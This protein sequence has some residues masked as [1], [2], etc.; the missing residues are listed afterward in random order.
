MPSDFIERV[1]RELEGVDSFSVGVSRV[2]DFCESN[3][4]ADEP[5]FSN[6]SCDSCG[7][8]VA[9]DRYPAHGRIASVIC[10]FSIC[11]DC[12]QFHANGDIPEDS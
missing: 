5:Y 4:H 6:C 11:S 10:C 7:T 2:C 3:P 1:E 8:T 12:V 9:G